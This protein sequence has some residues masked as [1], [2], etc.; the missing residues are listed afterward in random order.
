[1]KPPI[2]LTA[3]G[4]ASKA[5][6]TYSFMDAIIKRRFAD[7]EV[8]WA[9]TSR[10][11]RDKLKKKS[12]LSI[13]HPDTILKELYDK[14]HKWAVVQ[15]MHLVCGHEFYRLVDETKKCKIRTT[16]GLPLLTSY[17][18]Y[19]AVGSALSIDEYLQ[20]NESVI[21]VG[22]GTDHPAWT[23]YPA[24]ENILKQDYGPDIHVCTIEKEP[25]RN[26]FI[27][28]IVQTGV[29]QVILIPLMLVAGMHLE[30]DLTGDKD[31]W[32]K[33]FNEKNIFVKIEK[34]GLGFNK[35]VIDIFINHIQDAIDV[36]PQ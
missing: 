4:T 5:L 30:K 22:H 8:M 7:H 12:N 11:V 34:K 18:D 2:V 33:A 27:E 31:S 35:D 6:E 32:K 14:G 28:K 23:A 24:L 26:Q 36:I 16:I 9:Y 25:S 19:K 10:I 20:Q 15:S 13:S 3:F 21:L 17:N 1:M 29:K